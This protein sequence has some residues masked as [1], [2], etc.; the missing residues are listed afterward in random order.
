MAEAQLAG[1]E[2]RLS[3]HLNERW[4]HHS[5][6][7]DIAALIAEVRRLQAENVAVRDALID[8]VGQHCSLHIPNQIHDSGLSS[9]EHACSVLERIGV[10]RPVDGSQHRY[11]W[12]EIE[13]IK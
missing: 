9:D 10:I 7:A 6:Y 13:A 4:E 1:I 5:P 8:M 11:Q 3:T 2:Q 12:V